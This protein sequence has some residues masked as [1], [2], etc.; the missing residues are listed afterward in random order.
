VTGNRSTLATLRRVGW[1]LLVVAPEK[2]CP[3]GFEYAVDNGAW[4]A[5]LNGRAFDTGAFRATVEV[6]GAGA[7]WVVAPDIVQ[8]G[9][10]SLHVSES[11]LPWLFD[12]APITLIAV[13]DGMRPSDV[14]PIL[15]TCP[16]RIGIFLGG[17]TEWKLQ[18]LSL[19]GELAEEVGCYYHVGRVNSVKRIR[20]CRYAR[21]HSFDGSGPVKFPKEIP[22]RDN[23]RKEYLPCL[24]L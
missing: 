5:Y 22:L 19:W 15:R 17:S 3:E 8:G 7:D 21:A 23:A 1:R 24:P 18:M 2:T 9:R 13:Q 16:R 10:K 12:R 20:M 4:S 14:R 6:M 11:W